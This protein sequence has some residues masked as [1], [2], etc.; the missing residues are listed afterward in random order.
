M[1]PALGSMPRVV[2]L[3]G[4]F[5]EERYLPAALAHLEEQGVDV[6]LLDNESTDRSV[7]I[8]SSFLDRNV[9]G[10]ETLPNRGPF[11]LRQ[12]LARKEELAATLDADWFL[13]TDVDEFRLPPRAD[14]TLVEAIAEADEAGFNAVGF[15]EFVFVPTLE[16]PD[17][18]HENF[19]ETMR[20]YY[21]FRPFE[22]HRLN[23]WKRQDQP[24]DLTTHAGHRVDFPGLRLS[25]AQF[26]MRHYHFLSV[27]HAV[28]RHLSRTYTREELDLAWFGWR[29]HL[30]PEMIFL[31]HPGELREYVDDDQLDHRLPWTEHQL[32]R[33]YQAGRTGT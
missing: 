15:S 8:A 5:N 10:I 31:P 9:V 28:D 3:L 30:R 25:P 23:A 16:S 18:D 20:W 27:D 19:L 22:G 26:K 14:S 1:S 13:F 7:A 4:V 32:G 11:A 6:Y 12:K 2:A 24:V 29:P 33:C 21:P 17:H